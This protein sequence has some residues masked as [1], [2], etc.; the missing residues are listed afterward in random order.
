MELVVCV[1]VLQINRLIDEIDIDT[2]IDG[3]SRWFSGKEFIYVF[4]IHSAA[5]AKSL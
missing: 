2:D 5:A 3:L 1:R 4:Y